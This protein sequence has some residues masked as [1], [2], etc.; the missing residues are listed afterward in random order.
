LLRAVAGAAALSQGSAYMASGAESTPTSWSLAGF[1]VLSGVGLVAGFLTP[2]AAAG[3]SLST[4]AIAATTAPASGTGLWPH[5]QGPWFV[6]A[7]ALALAMLGPGSLS[8]DAWLFGRREIVIADVS[9][10]TPKR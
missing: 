10:R 8:I 5:W 9:R 3:V 4:L 1:A 7:V 2:A 6:A